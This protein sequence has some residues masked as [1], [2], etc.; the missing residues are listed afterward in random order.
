MTVSLRI[1][2]N[3][4]GGDGLARLGDGRVA[5]V[6]GAWTGE[7]VKAEIFEEKRNFV[8]ARLTEIVEASPARISA[9]E[10]SIVPGCVYAGISLSRE[11]AAKAL[12]I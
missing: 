6:A 7:L 12:Q 10:E 4:Y 3:V 9:A 8:R 2:K 5:F 1:I 11:T